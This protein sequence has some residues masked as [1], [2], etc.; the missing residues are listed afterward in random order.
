MVFVALTSFRGVGVFVLQKTGILYISKK[1]QMIYLK[2]ISQAQEVMIPRNGSDVTGNMSLKIQDT[3]DLQEF[4]LSVQDQHT[5]GLYFVVN[6]TLPQDLSDGEYKYTLMKG[7]SLL[8][9]GLLMV[10]DLADPTEYEKTIN[11]RQYE[12]E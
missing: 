6:V 3:T 10:G 12:S 7:D 8:S 9:N 5:S 1:A 2:N 11:Y 4:T